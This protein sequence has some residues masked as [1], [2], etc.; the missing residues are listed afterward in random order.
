MKKEET[1]LNDRHELFKMYS[2]VCGKCK[3]LNIFNLNC[4]AFPKGIPDNLL[5]GK[6]QHDKP[7]KGQTGDTVFANEF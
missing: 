6:I 5:E 2:S 3:H 4:P 7:I 1:V